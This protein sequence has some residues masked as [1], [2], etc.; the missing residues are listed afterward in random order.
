MIIDIKPKESLKEFLIQYNKIIKIDIPKA[1]RLIKGAFIHYN[2]NPQTYQA[3]LE[4][5]WYNSLEN[6]IDYSVY[7]DEYYFTD[8]W[9]CW[10]MYSRSYIRSMLKNNTVY[11]ELKD[12][13]SAVDLGCGVGYATSSLKEIFPK[14][15]VYGT[16]IEETDQYKFCTA[17][18]KKYNWQLIPTIF[19]LKEI[20]LVF[21]S[22]YFEH[23]QT[24]IPHLEQVLALNPK[25]LFIAN[26]FNTYSVGHFTKYINH[27]TGIMP[28]LVD[29]KDISKL[30]NKTL[31]NNGYEKLKTGLWN[32]KP[33]L[34]RKR[35]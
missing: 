21:A 20:D 6:I 25:Y 17:M 9:T 10:V 34:W 15:K 35:G 8:I 2:G 27:K 1:E 30:F 18:S 7:G 4:L 24:V 16:N 12:I 32:N 19:Q 23:I 5:Q 11:N 26:A 29:Q 3:Q 31:V 22:E 33:N 28:C 13:K 14:A